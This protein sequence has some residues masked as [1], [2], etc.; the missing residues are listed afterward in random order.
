M[1]APC[2]FLQ[3]GVRTRNTDTC[4]LRN[5]YR[6]AFEK[7]KELT[8]RVL[9]LAEAGKSK[10]NWELQGLLRLAAFVPG[11]LVGK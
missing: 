11:L 10:S 2:Y 8:D 7:E 5:V 9:K 6:T 1:G 3:N 4:F